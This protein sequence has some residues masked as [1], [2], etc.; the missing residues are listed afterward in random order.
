M[1][2]SYDSLACLHSPFRWFKSYSNSESR[3]LCSNA[4]A[5]GSVIS[6]S[7]IYNDDE[8]RM[9][10]GTFLGQPVS[11]LTRARYSAYVAYASFDI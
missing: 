8:Q 9:D 4:Q 1:R 7:V 6:D 5:V 10:P 3:V 2:L 11:E